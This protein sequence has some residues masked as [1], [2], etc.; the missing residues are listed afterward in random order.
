M[1]VT[2]SSVR[3]MRIRLQALFEVVAVELTATF[4]VEHLILGM[5]AAKVRLYLRP[6]DASAGLTFANFQV[7]LDRVGQIAEVSL[8]EPE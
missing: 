2:P 6:G 4:A 1:A 8:S 7:H 5:R 3:P